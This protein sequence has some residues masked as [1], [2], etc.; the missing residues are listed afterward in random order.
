M[1][2][3]APRSHPDRPGRPQG[4]IVGDMPL[5]VGVAMALF[6][7]EIMLP[8]LHSPSGLAALAAVIIL[9]TLG[10]LMIRKIIRIDV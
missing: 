1:R 10:G 6:R 9:I 7:P 5:V 2:I 3:E 8:Y 4:V